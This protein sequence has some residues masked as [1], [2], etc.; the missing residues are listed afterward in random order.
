MTRGRVMLGVGSGVLVS[1]A[2]MLGVRTADQRRRMQES[3]T[4]IMRL[5]RGDTVTAGNRLVC[6]TQRV[7]TVPAISANPHH[8]GCRLVHPVLRCPA[9]WPAN[10]A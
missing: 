4:V 10:G 8:G 6:A 7:P 1:D 9:H 3:L 2:M 5:L